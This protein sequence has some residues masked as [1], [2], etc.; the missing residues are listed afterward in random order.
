MNAQQII[1]VIKASGTI[2]KKGILDALCDGLALAGLGL[3]D[4]D[5]DAVEEAFDI[6]K[7]YNDHSLEDRP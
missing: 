5:Q 3:G 4:S 1:E 6:V 7:T 2:D